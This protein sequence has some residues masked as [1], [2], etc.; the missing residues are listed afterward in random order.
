VDAAFRQYPGAD[1]VREGKA[2]GQRQLDPISSR[3]LN[4]ALLSLCPGFWPFC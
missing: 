4:G 2:M 1:R 3:V